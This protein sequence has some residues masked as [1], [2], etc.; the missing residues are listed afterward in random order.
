MPDRRSDEAEISYFSCRGF[1]GGCAKLIFRRRSQTFRYRWARFLRFGT[2]RL[3]PV[4][5]ECTR[6]MPFSVGNYE[7]LHN[8][9]PSLV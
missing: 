5:V 6:F 7:T 9:K 8:L 3:A 2:G 1:S 4:F